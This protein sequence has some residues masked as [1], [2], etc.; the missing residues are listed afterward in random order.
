VREAEERELI[1]DAANLEGAIVTRDEI[2]EVVSA[3]PAE[4]IGRMLATLFNNNF[5]LAR[6]TP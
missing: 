3:Q 2:P 5:D 4:F 6:E 1:R